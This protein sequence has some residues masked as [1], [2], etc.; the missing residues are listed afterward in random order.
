MKSAQKKGDC[1]FAALQLIQDYSTSFDRLLG[2]LEDREITAKML[3]SKEPVLA[4]GKVKLDSGNEGIHAWIEFG[5]FAIDYSNGN[6]SVDYKKNV[7]KKSVSEPKLF[8]RD[9]VLTYLTHLTN[10]DSKMYW[11]D[12]I[13]PEFTPHEITEANRNW[14]RVDFIDCYNQGQNPIKKIKSNQSG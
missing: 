5:D 8:K 9:I 6:D 3:G 11:G 1:C 14:K 4:H 2:D 13:M 10:E 12:I 7:R